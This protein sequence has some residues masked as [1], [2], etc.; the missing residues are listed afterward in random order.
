MTQYVNNELPSGD[1]KV[2]SSA[3]PMAFL[4]NDG[5]AQTLEFVWEQNL[6]S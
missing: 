3:K 5:A 4:L 6:Y 2:W 1:S